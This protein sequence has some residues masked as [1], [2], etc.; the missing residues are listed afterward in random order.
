[1]PIYGHIHTQELN[2][3]DT[4][5]DV[6]CR[7]DVFDDAV[8]SRLDWEGHLSEPTPIIHISG[9]TILAELSTQ[10]PY[11][12]VAEIVQGEQ[13]VAPDAVIE[14]TWEIGDDAETVSAGDRF[15]VTPPSRFNDPWNQVVLE[16]HARIMTQ[17]G[18]Y[19]Y[20]THTIKVLENNNYNEGY[21][22]LPQG[23]V[24]PPQ[25]AYTFPMGAFWLQGPSVVLTP[26]RPAI[27]KMVCG[28]PDCVMSCYLNDEPQLC[29]Y[30]TWNARLG[31]GAY[32]LRVD[33]INSEGLELQAPLE[34]D[35]VVTPNLALTARCR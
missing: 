8:K 33:V 13:Y 16:A 1:M 18:F 7:T 32:T 3:A 15:T 21:Q 12:L 34:R 17:Q 6:S 19:V 29:D 10:K 14:W 24:W 25:K 4:S 20:R 9:P 35:F 26:D 23:M 28:F 31:P 5:T 11:E 27:A 2:N 30:G 22:V